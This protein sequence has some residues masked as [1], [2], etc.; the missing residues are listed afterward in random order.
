MVATPKEIINDLLKYAILLCSR[1]ELQTAG[2]YASAALELLLPKVPGEPRENF[3]EFRINAHFPETHSLPEIRNILHKS[4]DIRNQVIHNNDLRRVHGLIDDLCTVRGLN[5]HQLSVELDGE[6]F[7]RLRQKFRY[8]TPTS[9]PSA[10]GQLFAGFCDQDFRNLYEMRNTL[11][12]LKERLSPYCSK[13]KPALFFDEIS[14]AISAYVWLAAVKSLDD[15]R[16]KIDQPSLSV[17]ATNHDMRVYLDFGGRCKNQR[18][19]YYHLLLNKKLDLF[20]K[21]LGPEFRVF[22]TYWYF[23]LEN[24]LTIQQFAER[25]EHGELI[26]EDLQRRVTDFESL[27]DEKRTIPEN[28]LL[29]GRI[30]SKTEV[31]QAGIGFADEVCAAFSKLHPILEKL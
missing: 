27:I 5:K 8:S 23:N 18:K 3:Y 13:L 11:S 26:E 30:F 31:V 22:D 28:K 12:Y 24:I 10:L 7:R 4:R 21:A 9:S 17:L 25:R 14:E 2:Y 6:D 20:L 15:D 1:S 16:P 19:R 29:V